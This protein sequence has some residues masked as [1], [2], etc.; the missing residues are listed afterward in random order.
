MPYLFLHYKSR[1]QLQKATEQ[2]FHL[3]RLT[4]A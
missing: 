3:F 2:Q 4:A 1:F